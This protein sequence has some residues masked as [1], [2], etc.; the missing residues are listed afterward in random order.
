MSLPARIVNPLRSIRARISPASFRWTASGLIRISDRSTAIERT[1]LLGASPPPRGSHLERR[2]LHRRGLDGRLA[3]RAHLP[4]RLQRRLAVGARLL[5]LRRADRADEEVGRHLRATDR[6]IEVA[7][8]EPLLHRLDLELALAH[9]LQ[10]LGRPE[11]HVD[12][13]A[14]VGDDEADG[15]G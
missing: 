3:E 4:E 10:V 2:E 6:A 12:E 13:R 15:H 7:A 11:E 9:V 14:E 5:E 8:C 1:S